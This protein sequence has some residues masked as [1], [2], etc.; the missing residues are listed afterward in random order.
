MPFPYETNCYE[1]RKSN[2]YHSREDCIVKYYQMKEYEECGCNR[3][4]IYYNLV[5][6][7]D[8]KICSNSE[9]CDFDQRY[10]RKFLDQ[11]C[12]KNCF[13]EYFDIQI[14]GE[15]GLLL[16][17]IFYFAN[18]GRDQLLLRHYQKWF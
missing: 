8:L 17:N 14:T 4:W 11:I 12:P 18:T 16:K 2:S 3:K 10:D 6:R 1:Y 13:N 9:K 15:T 7:T 5:N